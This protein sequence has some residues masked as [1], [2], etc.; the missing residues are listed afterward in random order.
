[1][2]QHSTKR[3]LLISL[4]AFSFIVIT[5]YLITLIARGYRFDLKKGPGIKATGLLSA[6][7]TPK[8]ASVYINDKL[9][10]AT[11]DTINLPPDE[12]QIKIVKDGYLPWQKTVQI[13]KETVFQTETQL[14][15]SVPDLRPLTFTGALNPAASPDLSRIVYA[16]AS[17]SAQKDNGLYLIELNDNL[18]PLT[19]NTPKLIA[20]NYPGVDWSKFT[21]SFSPDSR[22]ILA[23]SSSLSY[24]LKIDTP[25]SQQNLFDVTPRLPLI[26]EEWN[27]QEQLNLSV[28]LQKLPK[29]LQELISTESSQ[30]LLF[31]TDEDKVLYLASKD[32]QIE[33]EI[34]TPPP[35][36]STQTQSRDI[37]AGSYYVYDIKDDTNFFIGSAESLTSLRWLP[38]S[39]N[40]IFVADDKLQVTEYDN[41]NQHTLFAGDF[42]HDT[43]F[44]W[45]DGNKIVTLTTPYQGASYNLFAITIR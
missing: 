18:I 19:R 20:P 9:F 29:E 39:N 5:T 38:N 15:R 44:P 36:Q 32:A 16:V 17:A 21:F 30:H 4:F 8:S 37:K 23:T 24:L 3:S 12:Y 28:K 26:K 10:T 40:L 22:E 27:Q 7:S 33:P 6:T 14:F 42:K 43:V 25:I 2:P 45:T 11:D 31:S 34:I 13:K 1:M 35:A 41:T